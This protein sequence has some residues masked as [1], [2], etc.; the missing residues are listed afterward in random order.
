MSTVRIATRG[1]NLAV[2]QSE[3]VAKALR[4]ALGCDT[5]LVPVRTT[6]DR[7]LDRPLA[8]IGGK[9]LF[10]KEVEEALRDGRADLAV[11][12]AKDLPAHLAP[13][14][15]LAAFPERADPRDA[16]CA[17]DCLS[18]AAL[19]QGARVGTGSVRRQSQLRA[20][21]PDLE[22]VGLRGNVE[23]R[24]RK[25]EA[26]LDAVILATSG[27]ERLGLSARIRERVAPE[28][29]LP[30]AGQGTLALQVRADDP[31]AGRL[32]AVDHAPTR[33]ATEAERAFLAA[34]EGDCGVPL[35]ALAEPAGEGRLRLRGLVARL[36]G[37]EVVA[38]EGED[39]VE[40]AAALGRRVG[41]D[42]RARG[43]DRILREHLHGSP[44]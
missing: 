25:M 20:W 30:A 2:T 22:I 18:L 13:E 11:H 27:L 16:F 42:V 31:L 40:H 3:L 14:L 28:R 21:R 35:A 7:I 1:S 37:G 23:T 9:G 38:G 5:Q 43:G 39:A 15:V 34:L 33:H 8:E 44:R 24:L 12:S 10:I 41:E 26:S 19:P 17:N 4:E 6:G 29:L 36:D 32:A